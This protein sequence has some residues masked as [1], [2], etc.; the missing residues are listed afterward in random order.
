MK[1]GQEHHR[2]GCAIV[3]NQT[4]RF[5]NLVAVH[6]LKWVHFQQD[7]QGLDLDL[8]YFRDV[9]KRE[10]DFV[11]VDGRRPVQCIECKWDDAD[12]S[13][14]L[15]YFKQRFPDCQAWQLSAVGTEN[16]QEPDGTRVCPAWV[17]LGSL[18]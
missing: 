5:E 8:R 6:L 1:K 4:A 10:V 12:L 13:P 7:T 11:I 16:Y 18:V 9:D 3:P 15:R 17:Y 2:L 14:H